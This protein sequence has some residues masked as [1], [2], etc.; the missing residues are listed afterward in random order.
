MVRV[1]IT[2]GTI[3]TLLTLGG[4]AGRDHDRE[5]ATA[6]SEHKQT[7]LCDT[8]AP[9]QAVSGHAFIASRAGRSA[10]CRPATVGFVEIPASGG[11]ANKS[12][13]A[14]VLP[15]TGSIVNTSDAAANSTGTN[16]PTSSTA[17]SSPRQRERVCSGSPSA[18]AA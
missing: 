18:R 6:H 5:G 13:T 9:T 7:P 4:N 2:G 1:Y 16:G 15:S 3:G 12:V 11:S 8:T 14:A 17:S 10:A